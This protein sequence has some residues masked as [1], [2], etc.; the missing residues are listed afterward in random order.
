MAG[1]N[2][3]PPT[4]R[5]NVSMHSNMSQARYEKL[6]AIQQREQR[7]PRI[8]QRS[9]SQT[10]HRNLPTSRPGT[11][12]TGL[13][14]PS[15]PATGLSMY[16]ELD[17]N[18]YPQTIYEEEEDYGSPPKTAASAAVKD[19]VVDEWALLNEL[20]ITA[21]QLE[22][23]KRRVMEIEQKNKVKSDL[24]NQMREKSHSQQLAR[25][26][27][28]Q[29]WREQK[30]RL[31]DW[32]EQERKRAEK[33]IRRMERRRQM[34]LKQME[35][36]QSTRKTQKERELD[37]GRMIAAQIREDMHEE[38]ERARQERVSAMEEFRMQCEENDMLQMLK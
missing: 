2:S 34:L 22:Q 10:S 20:D 5:S 27:A 36:A 12:A 11:G 21:Y 8:S 1:P 9:K 6:M 19:E 28:E 13:P 18:N 4:A 33:R 30:D 14:P 35:M 24:M 7:K 25:T 38:R 23:E 31:D 3:V 32:N 29:E 37:E 17:Q 26:I 15:R 16:D